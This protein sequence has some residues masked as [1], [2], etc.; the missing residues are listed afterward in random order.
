[1]NSNYRRFGALSSSVDP[2][3]L[4]LTVVSIGK[5]LIGIAGFF[6]VS[7]GL[8]PAAAQT[9]VQAIIDLTAQSIPLSFALW[10]A[11]NGLW[12]AVRK[13]LAYFYPATQ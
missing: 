2:N 5:V 1:M 6:A 4:S 9:Q 11:C 7:K 13:L 8:D 12:G 10:H 3:E